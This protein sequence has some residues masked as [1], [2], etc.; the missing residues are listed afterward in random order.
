MLQRLFYSS[1]TI[2]LVLLVLG[3]CGQDKKRQ[4]ANNLSPVNPRI[5]ELDNIK[6]SAML[7]QV[8]STKGE[9][10]TVKNLENGKELTYSYTEARNAGQIK[11]TL[12][13]GDTLSIF[14][15]TKTKKLLISI[16]VSELSGRWFYDMAEHR[17]MTFSPKGS[18][19]SINANAISYREWKLLNGKLYIYYVDMQQ[20]ANDRHQYLVEEADIRSLSRKHLDFTFLNRDFSCQRLTT[21]IKFGSQK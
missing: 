4:G 9:E 12:T 7:V 15:E 16:N 8:I 19:S 3:S 10:I 20:A 18:M 13:T 2:I 21:V 11:G 1:A 6:D 14:P 17:G 5:E